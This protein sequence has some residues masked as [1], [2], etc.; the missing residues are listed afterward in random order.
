M[1]Q[2]SLLFAVVVSFV[3]SWGCNDDLVLTAEYKDIPIVYGLLSASDSAHY[4]RIEKAF[5]DPMTSALEIAQNVDSLYYKNLVVTLNH[6]KSGQQFLLDE[7][8]GNTE[9]YVLEEGIFANSPNVLYKIKANKIDL[10]VGDTYE[11]SISRSENSDLVTASTRIVGAPFI[12]RPQPGV[13]L[14]LLPK[15]SFK[16]FWL[17]EATAAFYDVNMIVHVREGDPNEPGKFNRK[18]LKWRITSNL[19]DREISFDGSDFFSF[20][21]GQLDAS[22]NVTR[23]LDSIDVQV[24]AGGAEL[25]EFVRIVQANTGITSSQEIPQFTNIS[26]G[27]GIF[28][29]VN[30]S[31]NTGFFLNEASRDT[32]M[33]GSI[34]GDLNFK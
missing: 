31:T 9:G 6:V 21:N 22:L 14:Q 29:S 3:A 25:L 2:K 1:F 4:L 28:S 30:Q 23:F 7:V 5:L 16:I 20:L 17:E 24:G 15:S 33:N 27:L 32:L 8:D 12:Q 10:E 19:Q 13:E 34:T 11:L 18:E 26:E